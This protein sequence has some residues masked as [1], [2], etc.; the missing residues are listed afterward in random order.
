MDFK[1]KSTRQ[2]NGLARGLIRIALIIIILAWSSLGGR[3]TLA[4]YSYPL[5]KDPVADIFFLDSRQGWIV[6]SENNSAVL[7]HTVDGGESWS[8][9]GSQ[10]SS[11][12]LFFLNA[13]HGWALTVDWPQPDTPLTALN[14]TK[15][16][17]HTWSRNS[18]VI[19]AK[20]NASD[21]ILDFLFLDDTRGWLVGQGGLGSGL[22]F[23][24]TDGGQSI[25][26]VD[27]IPKGDSILQRL[28][29]RGKDK[30]WIF[31]TNSITASFDGG[32]TWQSQLD[33]AKAP[34]ALSYVGL[35]SGVIL[36]TGAGW[37]TGGGAGATILATKD[38]GRTWAISLESAE[39]NWLDD[40][41]FWDPS[42]G[43]AVGA[44]TIL[45]CTVDG[46]RSWTSSRVLP[47]A[48]DRVAVTHG[49]NVDNS[50]K[51]IL[52]LNS[53]RGWVL[54][55]SGFLF[56]TDD[57]GSTWHQWAGG[58]SSTAGEPSLTR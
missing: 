16:G 39:G 56:Q 6:G 18:I 8:R 24:T 57:G 10:P 13:V 45:Y 27:Q 47:K 48:V 42:H 21:M 28:Y 44:S 34:K 35:H 40:I 19:S 23:E 52:L 2:Q 12:K 9:F 15:D 17:G 54:S 49:L 46:G 26:P 22:A 4:Q 51:R 53:R 50:F 38:F 25:H 58:A 29:A 30:I 37:A 7:Y 1:P 43:C 31:G 14:E 36:N 41:S 20:T 11:Y 3:A 5:A 55:E 33:T 32:R